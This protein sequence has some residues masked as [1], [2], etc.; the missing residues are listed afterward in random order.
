[1]K[2]WIYI[3]LVLLNVN[4]FAQKGLNEVELNV[5]DSSNYSFVVSGHFYGNQ[6][7]LSGYPASSVLGNI[8]LLTQNQSFIITLGD[9]F[10]DVKN[11]IP[12][13]QKS[14]F[15]KVNIPIFNAVGNHDLTADIYQEN[16]GKTFF[17][18]RIG[19]TEYVILD[20]EMNDGSIKGEQLELLKTALSSNSENLLIFAHRPI[21]AESDSELSHLFKDNTHSLISNNYKSEVLPLLEQ[22]NKNIYFFGGSIGSAAPASF[23]YH[24]KQENITYVAT[25]IRDFKRDAILEVKIDN[26]SISFNPI[27]LNDQNLKTLEAYDLS[28][29]GANKGKTFNY[30][31]LPLYVKQMLLG[32]QFWVGVVL[33]LLTILIINKIRNGR[34]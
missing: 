30:R 21:W 9:M 19:T 26:N 29:W 33:M 32:Y 28:F 27:S 23:F 22:S 31:L 34:K 15:S 12:F 6:R 20:T 11:D 24:K 14:F 5:L 4:S 3:I 7:N 16:F 2:N 1:M 25:A 13:Y 18:Y 8:D 17:S 10:L